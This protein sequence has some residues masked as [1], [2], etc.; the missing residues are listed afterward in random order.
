MN[1]NRNENEI[2]DAVLA[3]FPK[4]Y[5]GELWSGDDMAV[6]ASD[7]LFADKPTGKVMKNQPGSTP[8][9]DESKEKQYFTPEAR[10][11]SKEKGHL[12][13]SADCLVENVHF[14][15]SFSS[16]KD[17]GYKA[18]AVNISD[19]AAMGA[20]PYRAVISIAARSGDAV[21]ELMKG[22]A[23][24]AEK[25]SCPIVGGDLSA[26]E[27]IFISVAVLAISTGLPPV[28]RSGAKPGDLLFVTGPLGAGLAGLHQ[29]Q[30]DPK[31]N[32]AAANRHR[33]P[34]ARLVA[35]LAAKAAGATAMMDLSDGILT[36]SDRLG[37][38]SGVG[39]SIDRCPVH[40]LATEEEAL[41]GGDDYEL[42]FA[43]K[44]TSKVEEAFAAYGEE[45][46]IMIGVCLKDNKARLYKGNPIEMRGFQHIFEK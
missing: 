40:E 26:A 22:A 15:R 8:G 38:A 6:F 44:E 2:L 23:E 35:G 29:L 19:V 41:T 27:N 36:D 28:L 45:P 46:P 4:A 12:L 17:V 20:L 18:L 1:Q 11:G 9:S 24:A 37:K 21:E 14:D 10:Q 31:C 25:Y 3:A 34:K 43:A 42:L 7:S 16:L 13:F 5:P 39:V 32:N 33:R 30:R